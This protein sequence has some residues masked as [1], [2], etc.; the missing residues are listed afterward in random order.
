MDD[1]GP[2]FPEYPLR[3]PDGGY[4]QKPSGKNKKENDR[5]ENE[6]IPPVVDR[7]YRMHHL[8]DKPVYERNEPKTK[9]SCK[10]A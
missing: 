9:S 4:S 8:I 3:E 2:Q 10:N 7:R 5:C 6:D 1:I